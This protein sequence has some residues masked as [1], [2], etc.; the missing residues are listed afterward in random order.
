MIV[1]RLTSF[2]QDFVIRS[3]QVTKNVRSGHD[4]TRTSSARSPCY[5]RLQA[6]VTIWVLRKVCR[7]YAYPNPVPLFL[8]TPLVIHEKNWKCLDIQAQGIQVA[9]K[10]YVHRPNSPS[11]PAANP[12][13]HA[14]YLFV[15]LL[16][17][18]FYFRFRFLWVSCS[19]FPC[20]SSLALPLLSCTGFSVYLL[21]SNTE[22]CDEDDAKVDEGVVEELVDK[23]GT[24]NGT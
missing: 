5:F 2:T 12:A 24:T 6:D 11:T 13:I 7:H 10:Y 19:G 22:S 16:I 23:P 14:I 9:L 18:H 21:T 15:L 3:Y 4:C 1:S 20:S 8:A 17:H